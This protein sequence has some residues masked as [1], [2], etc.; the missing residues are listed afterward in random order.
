MGQQ[1][2]LT[3]KD[4]VNDKKEK[5]YD[6]REG[7]SGRALGYSVNCECI[8]LGVRFG[9]LTPRTVRDSLIA[10]INDKIFIGK[11]TAEV[12][13]FEGPDVKGK[14]GFVTWVHIAGD[15]QIPIIDKKWFHRE[16]FN[17]KELKE[18]APQFA[19]VY[20]GLYRRDL[21]YHLKQD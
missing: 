19:D 12:T 1:T 2:H 18:F 15:R 13:I 8:S 17:F 16:F 3:T 14:D 21:G 4:P 9:E 5:K 11:D 6:V 20:Q 7:N 10:E